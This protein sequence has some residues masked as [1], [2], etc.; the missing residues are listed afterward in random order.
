MK[1]ETREILNDAAIVVYVFVMA[2]V[3]IMLMA[4]C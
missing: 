2:F 3:G 4:V 1:R